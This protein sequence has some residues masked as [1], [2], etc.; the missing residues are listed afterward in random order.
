VKKAYVVGRFRV[1]DERDHAIE[2]RYGT[3]LLWY[4]S[5]EIGGV[6]VADQVVVKLDD[7]YVRLNPDPLIDRM[8]VL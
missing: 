5:L 6:K 3:V 8:N 2:F 7:V 1:I 4:E